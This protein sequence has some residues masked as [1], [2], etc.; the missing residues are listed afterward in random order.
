MSTF[1][2][3]LDTDATLFVANDNVQTTLSVLQNPADTV[4]IVASTVGWKVYMIAT[5]DNEQQLV[6]AV[7]GANTLQ[8][9]R[10]FNGAGS[11][12]HA[13][14]SKVSNF[15]DSAYHT[16]MSSAMQA[17]QAALLGG[18]WAQ[19][20][21]FTAEGGRFNWSFHDTAVPRF[22]V[23]VNVGAAGGPWGFSEYHNIFSEAHDGL[24]GV[25]Y[26][27]FAI[28]AH[29]NHGANGTYFGHYVNATADGDWSPGPVGGL[30]T[31]GPIGQ[32]VGANSTRGGWA[33]SSLMYAV[34]ST[35]DP[36]ARPCNG[37]SGLEIAIYYNQSG[38]HGSKA[39]IGIV[40]S[41]TGTTDSDFSWAYGVTALPGSQGFKYGLQFQGSGGA[42][43]ITPGGTMIEGHGGTVYQGIDWSGMTFTGPILNLPGFQLLSDGKLIAPVT[44]QTPDIPTAGFIVATADKTSGPLV[45]IG[46]GI[47]TWNGA[48]AINVNVGTAGG[49]FNGFLAAFLVNSVSKFLIDQNGAVTSGAQNYI[50]SETGANNAIVA[51][52][53][54]TLAAGLTVAIKLAHTLQ[55]GVN[56]LNGVPIRSSRNPANNI[57]TAYAVG[58]IVSLCYDGTVYQDVSQ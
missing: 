22:N 5:V 54:V 36:V 30:V 55:V 27:A 58:A 51:A 49:T 13:A 45:S 40:D 8:V 56:T 32:F 38:G 50:A 33:N 14:G 12:S 3:A 35:D 31:C 41:G 43:G 20:P 18:A 2:A 16:A 53:P 17:T 34:C 29:L 19:G 9:T 25:A 15:V 37:A 26:K 23:F 47:S 4:A 1:P 24:A 21:K 46:H 6:T 57:A 48:T 44:I 52:I 39:G 28:E 10:N 42:F 7:I 11:P